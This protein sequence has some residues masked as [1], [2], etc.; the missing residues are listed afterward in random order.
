MTKRKTREDF[1]VVQG[2]KGERCLG[3]S[4]KEA[5]AHKVGRKKEKSK[6]VAKVVR[7]EGDKA[8]E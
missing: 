2:A 5:Y 3:T 7:I 4:A 8:L 1:R 6:N